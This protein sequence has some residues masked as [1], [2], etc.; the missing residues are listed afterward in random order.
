MRSAR[1]ASALFALSHLA[2]CNAIFGFDPPKPLSAGLSQDEL[3][4]AIYNERLFELNNEAKR[5]QDMI[6]M[7]TFTGPF[8]FKEQREPY[9]ILFPI[10]VTQLQTNPMLVQNPGY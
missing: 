4:T 5:R 9:R 3:R 8:Q 6:R 1:L 7:G 10:P 2:A